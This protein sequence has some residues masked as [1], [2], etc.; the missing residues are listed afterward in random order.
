MRYKSLSILDSMGSTHY[1]LG[2]AGA[3]RRQFLTRALAERGDQGH[4]VRHCGT[5]EQQ[6][7]AGRGHGPWMNLTGQSRG[8]LFCLLCGIGARVRTH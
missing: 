3:F 4:G 8:S 2:V 1:A 7:Q 6:R 5:I